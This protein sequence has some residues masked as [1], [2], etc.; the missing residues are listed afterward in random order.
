MAMAAWGNSGLVHYYCKSTKRW[1]KVFYMQF[2]HI[3]KL[4]DRTSIIRSGDLVAL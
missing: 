3:S 1:T 4:L 2:M